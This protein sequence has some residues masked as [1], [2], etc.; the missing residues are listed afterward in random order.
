MKTHILNQKCFV[1]VFLIF[2]LTLGIKGAIYSADLDVGE[3]RTVRMIYFLP[4]DRPYRADIVQKMKD[5]IRNFQT[6]Y[7]EQMQAHGYGKKTFRFEADA[8]GEPKVHRVDGQYA[9]SYYVAKDGG[10]LGELEQKFD[11]LGPNIYFIVWDNNTNSIGEGVGGAGGGGKTWGKLTVPSGFDFRVAVHELGHTFGLGHDFRDETYVMS[12]GPEPDRLSAC[13]AGFLAVHP[14]FNPAIPLEEGTRPTIELISPRT[15]PA[16]SE[17]VTIRLKVS[18]TDGLHQARL[19]SYGGLNACRELRRKEESIVEFEYEGA[20]SSTGYIG[21]SD[22]VTHSFLVDVVDTNGDVSSMSFSLAEVSQHHITTLEGHVDVVKSLMFSPDGRILATGTPSTVKLWD[23][24]TQRNIATFE[25]RSVAFS[26]DGRILATGTPSTV[27]LW[28]VRTQRNI[29]ILEGHASG[30]YSLA[31][32]PDGKMLASGSYDGMITLWDVRTPREIFTFEA[33]MRWDEWT[34]SVLTLAFSPDGKMLASGAHDGMIKLWDVATGTN[35]ASIEEEGYVPWIYSVA[36]SP[37]G[38]MLASGRG[39]GRGNVKLW[40]VTTKRNIAHFI[41][42]FGVISVAFS[43]DGRILASGSRDGIVTL[44]DVITGT[45]I[46]D[47]P[48]TSGVWSVAFSPDGK[49][50]ASGTWDG[51]VELWD[52][53][54]ARSQKSAGESRNQIAISEIMFASNN[55]NLPQWIELHNRSK[56]HSVNLTGWKL[57][58]QNRHS[59]DFDGH[60]NATITFKEKFIKPQDTLLIVS[61][62]GRSSNNFRDEQIYNLSVLHPNL[63]D[64]VL[65]EEGIYLKLHNAAGEL[66]DEMG[67]LDGKSDT[68]DAP[69]WHLPENLT[70]GRARASMIRRHDDGVPFLGTVKDGWVSA[71]HTELATKTTTY[72]GHPNDIGAP[73]I[74]SGGALPVTLSYFRADRTDAGVVVKWTTESELDNA[75]FNI[76]RSETKNGKFKVVNLKGII[77]GHGTT[78]GRHTYTWIDT[79]AKTNVAY[80]Y[81][82]EDVSHAGVRKQLATVRMRGLV[83]ASGKL[84]TRWSDLKLQK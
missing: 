37:D 83:S 13:T 46:A 32:S 51:T 80:Y 1:F 45:H 62:R 79:T 34:K 43:P 29:T 5:E 19:Y 27:K 55:G 75:G 73:G 38:R 71:R 56:T 31:F 15:Y 78:N 84:I 58:I 25:G 66:I 70:Q 16:G 52:V 48:H 49:T 11:M 82:I 50:L 39:N 22:A 63:Q 14:Y 26:P 18:D 21:L 59:A 20:I 30:G 36:F 77:S 42:I 67:N 61:K 28:D 53:E 4:N 17:S 47:L 81:Q 6:F 40:D 72:Y 69:V 44:R 35:I 33:H 76:L 23:V 41:H 68:N 8:K 3:P 12:Y 54:L 9:D 7:A 65:S 60:R 10:F 24:A 57:E 64:M 2:F 74:K